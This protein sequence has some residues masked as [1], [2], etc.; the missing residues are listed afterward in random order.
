[1]AFS[2][3]PSKPHKSVRNLLPLIATGCVALVLGGIVSFVYFQFQA[4]DAQLAEMAE[5]I[6]GLRQTQET[7]IVARA[8][9]PSVSSVALDIPAVAPPSPAVAPTPTKLDVLQSLT[10]EAVLTAQQPQQP[11]IDA[12]GFAIL[13]LAV[14]GVNELSLAANAGDYRLLAQEGTPRIVFPD[15][16]EKQ[17]QLENI[18]AAAAVDG[19]IPYT[20]AA[21]R[22]DGSV[23]GGVILLD[24]IKE[25]L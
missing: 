1:M 19:F 10:S 5:M 16:I 9:M 24:L 13:A 14:Q 21:Q 7:E 15:H 22:E 11:F 2:H 4:R 20:R 8:E 12:G 23:D 17:A 18:L 6:E 3:T 25:A